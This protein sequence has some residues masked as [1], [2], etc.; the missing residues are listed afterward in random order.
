MNLL[1]YAV[2][3]DSHGKMINFYVAAIDE[4]CIS[5]QIGMLWIAAKCMSYFRPWHCDGY[6]ELWMY[7]VDLQTWN[8]GALETLNNVPYNVF[9]S[10][11]NFWHGIC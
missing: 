7:S 6:L 4:S 8:F 5:S 11:L 2:C 1:C 10:H 9:F 3:V